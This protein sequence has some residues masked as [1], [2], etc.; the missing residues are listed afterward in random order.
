MGRKKT[1]QKAKRYEKSKA[2]SHRGRHIGGP[3]EED[4]RRGKDVKGEVKNRKTPV[5]KPELMRLAKRG[6]TEVD[7]KGGYTKPAVEYATKY[8]PE[9]KLFSRGRR[10]V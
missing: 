6:I 7:S 9:M 1:M 4:Y 8:R 5:T 2:K 10:I 3:G